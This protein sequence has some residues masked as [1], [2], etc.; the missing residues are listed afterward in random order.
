[1]CRFHFIEYRLVATS[2]VNHGTFDGLCVADPLVLLPAE[3]PSAVIRFHIYRVNS[4]A[5]M[6]GMG[7]GGGHMEIVVGDVSIYLH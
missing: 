7:R 3:G 4:C 2:M 5:L 1:M 6:W